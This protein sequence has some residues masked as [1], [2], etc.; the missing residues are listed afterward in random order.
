MIF[1]SIPS[2]TVDAKLQPFCV[3]IICECLDARGEVLSMCN[4]VTLRNSNATLSIIMVL[5]IIMQQGGKVETDLTTG[6]QKFAKTITSNLLI[7]YMQQSTR[8]NIF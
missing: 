5:K 8:T 7:I 6:S 4:K 3:H 1:Y 2:I